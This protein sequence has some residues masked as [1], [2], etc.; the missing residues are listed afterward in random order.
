[1]FE[2]RIRNQRWLGEPNEQSH[3]GCS[4]GGIHAVIA[5]TVVTSEDDEYGISQ[6]ALSLLRTLEQDHTRASP[7]SGGYLLCH[8]CGYPIAFGCSNFGTDWVVHHDGDTVVLTQATHYSSV[9]A[10]RADPRDTEFD[11]HARVP[12]E[13]YRRQI[14][15]FAGEVRDFFAT[16]EPRQLEDWE[17]ELHEQFWTEFDER[18]E[19]ATG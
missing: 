16:S 12:V 1:V 4:H 2:L 15:A 6:S 8:G 18:L 14:V 9:P 13:R 3:D 10:G 7:V 17:Q 19:R 11:V 5:G